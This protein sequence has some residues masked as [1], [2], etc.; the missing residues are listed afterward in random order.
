M[1]NKIYICIYLYHR[2]HERTQ[3][4]LELVFEELLHIAAL[5]H[6]STS[7]KRELASIIVFEAHAQAGTIRKYILLHV[8]I[9]L[10]IF[11]SFVHYDFLINSSNI[12]YIILCYTIDLIHENILCVHIFVLSNFLI[13]FSSIFVTV[14]KTN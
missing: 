6:L 7:I 3:E 8:S 2:S 12:I 1:N 4:E 5:S 10:E 11:D 13:L 14:C 9:Y